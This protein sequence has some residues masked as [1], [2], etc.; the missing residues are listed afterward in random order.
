MDIQTTLKDHPSNGKSRL[1]CNPMNLKLGRILVVLINITLLAAIFI[2]LTEFYGVLIFRDGGYTQWS[3]FTKCSV[4][5]GGGERSRKRTC[6]N[7]PP[8]IGGVD[9][10]KLGPSHE[11]VPCNVR[12]CPIHGGFERW[13]NFGECSVPCGGGVQKRVRHCINPVP[14]FGGKDCKAQG[15]G[16]YEE[17]RPCN[18][19]PCSV[20]G[21]YTDWTE[22][23][24][25]SISCGKG[26]KSRDRECTN[27][28]PFSG[29]SDCNALG[30]AHESS[31]CE[32]E[33]PVN[34]GYGEWTHWDKC[35]ADCGGGWHTRTRAC[36]SPPPSGNGKTCEEMG[37]GN[38]EDKK[39]CHTEPCNRDG[40][41]SAWSVWTECS[42]TCGD[43]R[44]E[45]VRKCNNPKPSGKGKS[46]KE[47]GLGPTIEMDE[48]NLKDCPT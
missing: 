1:T 42:K 44:I 22:W 38:K 2:T 35:T 39:P 3:S 14:K 19:Q 45:R 23:T 17:E 21:G 18:E 40:G 48:C 43:G 16:S 8:T 30:P 24:A 13:S 7:P 41:Y 4:S 33:C 37:Y 27:P 10:A 6:T 34:G 25:C 12:D 47:Q 26:T 5:C 36:D 9:C 29:G 20:N 28:K 11:V 32:I 46:C 31:E 15:L